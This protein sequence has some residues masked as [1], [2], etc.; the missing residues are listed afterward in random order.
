M[1][2]LTVKKIAEKIVEYSVTSREYSQ[3]ELVNA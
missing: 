3:F 1:I 2:E